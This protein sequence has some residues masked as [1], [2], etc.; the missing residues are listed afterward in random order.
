MKEKLSFYTPPMPAIDSYRGTVEAAVLH[1]LKTVECLNIYE[2]ATPDV[3]AA[4]ELRA[5][6]DACGIRFS[7]FSVFCNLVG[8][9]AAETIEMVKGY[10]DVA[11]ALGSPYLHHTIVPEYADPQKV[12]PFAEEYF[13]QGIRAVREIYDYAAA[14]GVRT[15]YE[16]QGF[17]FNGVRN[18]GRFL[19]EVERDVGVVADFGNITQS[20][21]SIPDFLKAYAP[22][23]CHVHVKDVRIAEEDLGGGLS[24]LD[25]KYMHEVPLGQGDVP[26]AQAVALL[27]ESGYDGYYALETAASES[28]DEAVKQ[29]VDCAVELLG[30]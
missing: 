5:Y 28:T 12:T 11:A 4:K 14:R 19:N 24:T 6:A 23:V 20:G 29:L 22:R 8:E 30:V 13:A 27:R 18:F 7:C 17:L 26:F 9:T 2:F 10:A 25:G 1:G 15:I 21:E 3:E 16:D